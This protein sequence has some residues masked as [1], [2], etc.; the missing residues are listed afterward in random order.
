VVP[1]IFADMLIPVS[2]QTV[3]A[4]ITLLMHFCG[5]ILWHFNEIQKVSQLHLKL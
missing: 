5:F 4:D 2:I 1:K 3:E